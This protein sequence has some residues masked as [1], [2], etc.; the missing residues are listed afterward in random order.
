M[1]LKYGKGNIADIITKR[2][3]C[4]EEDEAKQLCGRA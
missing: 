1:V 4:E 3:A 2:G